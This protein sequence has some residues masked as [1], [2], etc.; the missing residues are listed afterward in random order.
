M[1]TVSRAAGSMVMPPTM[2]VSAREL[3]AS[4]RPFAIVTSSL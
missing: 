3:P 4:V 1:V 2:K